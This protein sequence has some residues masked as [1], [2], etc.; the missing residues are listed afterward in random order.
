M[1]CGGVDVPNEYG[2]PFVGLMPPQRW[3]K[4]SSARSHYARHPPEL[5]K[6][7]KCND[8]THSLKETNAVQ[9]NY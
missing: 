8:V 4:R 9:C 2:I 3:E 6:Q 7:N 5:Q 1:V